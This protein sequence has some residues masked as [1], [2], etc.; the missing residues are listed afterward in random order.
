M[1][2]VCID[3]ENPA[4]QPTYT[5]LTRLGATG[6]HMEMRDTNEFYTYYNTLRRLNSCLL[7]GPKTEDAF[8][9]SKNLPYE[10]DI[11]VIGNEPDFQSPS[12]WTMTPQEYISLYNDTAPLFPDSALSVAGMFNKDAS[13]LAQVLPHLKPSPTYV[14]VHY[15][16]AVRDLQRFMYYRSVIVGEWCYYTGTTPQIVDW[17]KTLVQ[18]AR[19]SFWF[20]WSNAQVINMGLTDVDGKLLPTYYGYKE[21]LN[22]L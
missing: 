10:P 8:V 15:P 21:A 22:K 20:C 18:Y 9:I 4:G 13:Y 17:N 5:Q 11:V 14:N 2:G 3:S 6:F 1:R 19:H 7:V 16:D 12:S